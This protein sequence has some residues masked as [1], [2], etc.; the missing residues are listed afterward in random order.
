[1]TEKGERKILPLIIDL[2]NPSP[3]I[4]INNTERSSFIERTRVDLSL[5]LALIHHLSIGKNIPFEKIAAFFETITDNL[6]IEFI[7]KTDEKIQFMLSQKEDIYT[8]YTEENFINSFERYFSIKN[9]Q[10]IANSGRILYLMT[11]RK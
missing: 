5:A 7:P 2:S 4:G 9:K 10:A 3:A 1:M 8:N 6:I 11:K